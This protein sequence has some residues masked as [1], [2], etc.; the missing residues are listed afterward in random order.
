MINLSRVDLNL[1]VVLHTILEEGGV[2]RAATKLNL[3]QST[4]SH[5]LARLRAEFGEELFARQGRTLVPTAL[6]KS[7]QVPLAQALQSLGAVLATASRFDPRRTPAVFTVAV[8]DP[9]EA[10]IVPAMARTLAATA[11]TVEMRCVQVRRRAIEAG[12]ADGSLDV[13][14]DIPLALSPSIRR[15]QVRVDDLVVM[16]RQTHPRI[17]RKLTLPRYLELDHVRVT[18]RRRGAAPEDLALAELGFHR[19]VRLRSRSY[20]AALRVVEQTDFVLTVPRSAI[21]LF[22][23]KP[24]IRVHPLPF[25]SNGLESVLY[26]HEAMDADPANRWLRERLLA[27]V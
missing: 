12:L 9:M 16:A 24:S 7:L 26:W 25:A 14:I 1:L 8:R 13:A 5:A 18:S 22:P 27:A 3:T 19:R 23:R 6:T 20:A 17:G 11:S 21:G 4:V 15:R 10:L 2:S